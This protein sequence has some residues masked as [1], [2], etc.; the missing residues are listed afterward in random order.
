M[1]MVATVL[2]TKQL[3]EFGRSYDRRIPWYGYVFVIAGQ[4]FYQLLLSAAA[5]WALIRH[6]LGYKDW[7]K[8]AREED[9]TVDAVELQTA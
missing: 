4:V 9:L 6:V 3:A 5:L 7:H 2:Q 1:M 8:T